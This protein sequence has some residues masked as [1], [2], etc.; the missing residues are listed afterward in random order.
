MSDGHDRP[1][2]RSLE[3][4]QLGRIKGIKTILLS[5]Q[6][7]RLIESFLILHRNL[8][9]LTPF[10]L[11][12][13]D[14]S[15]LPS[16][17]R[18]GKLES[19]WKKFCTFPLARLTGNEEVEGD[20]QAM[21]GPRLR[22]F[23]RA[24]FMNENYRDKRRRDPLLFA[25]LSFLDWKRSALQVPDHFV[26]ESLKKHRDSLTTPYRAHAVHP[27]FLRE[28]RRVIRDVFGNWR[29]PAEVPRTTPSFRASFNSG[30][31][32]MGAA[33][34]LLKKDRLTKD[35][36]ILDGLNGVR[37]YE[38]SRL[39]SDP[40][41]APD[42]TVTRICPILE[43]LK[44]RIISAE[45]EYSGLLAAGFNKSITAVLK[46]HPTFT[47]LR[48][49]VIPEDFSRIF[50][51]PTILSG[52]Y[53]AATDS[54]WSEY[55]EVVLNELADYV[56]GFIDRLR[57]PLL[58]ALTRHLMAYGDR[59]KGLTLLEQTRG[60]L[61]GS[62]VSFPILSLINATVNS[63]FLREFEGDRRKLREKPLQIHGDDCI[64]GLN[65]EASTSTLKAWEAVAG[66]VGFVSSIGKTL[67]SENFGSFCSVYLRCPP[68][69]EKSWI[70]TP[71]SFD[72]P[73]P[74]RL[75]FLR[76]GFL[77]GNG[78][79]LGNDTILGSQEQW[80]GS[81]FG[82]KLSLVAEEDPYFYPSFLREFLYFQRESLKEFKGLYFLPECFGG[83]GIPRPDDHTSEEL[84]TA[85]LVF[86]Q[87]DLGEKYRRPW[88]LGIDCQAVSALESAKDSWCEQQGYE[89]VPRMQVEFE[90][91]EDPITPFHLY[92]FL[93]HNILLKQKV[94]PR[95]LLRRELQK[96]S[97]FWPEMKPEMM[98]YI[99]ERNLIG[100]TLVPPIDGA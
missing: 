4:S 83:L 15:R 36:Q 37:I 97:K 10:R 43:P 45:E 62:G 86:S 79:V 92:D 34:Y 49:P 33:G 25:A 88:A 65:A 42:R 100:Y 71:G 96:K 68:E 51:H 39:E 60:Q 21:L 90:L 2:I 70:R 5:S 3:K 27:E 24:R 53:S 77:Y 8:E 11:E 30:R 73:V 17:E 26:E 50:A 76:T 85:Q 44:V 54:I 61:M 9:P 47:A 93:H 72:P 48:R 40:E 98:H 66:I 67:I 13:L 63:L 59:K 29:A 69:L 1:S 46:R 81:S 95:K 80:T 94:P 89:K 32:K 23:L 35:T 64:L 41:C 6:S 7:Y 57:T 56:G 20:Y 22:R 58:G 99:S 38:T 31:S 74:Q 78:R 28:L 75:S 55:S 19:Y 52:D 82:D 14:I 18:E 12:N 16:L 91:P 87:P 84:R